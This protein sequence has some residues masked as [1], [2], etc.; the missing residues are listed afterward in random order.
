MCAFQSESNIPILSYPI[1]PRS[2]SEGGG[3]GEILQP[4]PR[5]A[6]KSVDILPKS[7]TEGGGGGEMLQPSPLG[8]QEECGYF[9]LGL[10]LREEEGVRCSSPPPGRPG[11]CG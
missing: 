8:S 3:G 4:S 7:D 6:R 11:S 9:Y 5:A 10:I 1:L 2:D